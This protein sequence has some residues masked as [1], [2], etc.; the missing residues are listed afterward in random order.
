MSTEPERVPIP[1]SERQPPVGAR[2][3]GSPDPKE[4]MEVSVLLR[5]RTAPAGGGP[6]FTPEELAERP[7][8]DRGYPSRYELAATH[9]ADPTDLNKIKTFAHEHG[10]DVVEESV[11]RRVVILSGTIEALGEAFGVQL[12]TY[13]HGAI[14]YRGY[15]GPLR[16]PAF[17]EEIIQGVFGLDE[18]PIAHP[19]FRARYIRPYAGGISYTPTQVAK[20]YDFPQGASGQ[21]Q[22]IALIELGGGY[23]R[24]D[25]ESYFSGLGV[26]S[27]DVVAVSVDGA[28]NEPTGDPSGPDG[29][30]VL[31]IEVAGALAPGARIVVYFAPNTERGFIDAVSRAVH[32]E[33][34]NPTVISISWGAP[35]DQWSPQSITAFQQSFREAAMLGVTIA[36]AAGDSGSSDG[37]N[38]GLQHVDFPA[39]SPYVLGCGGT[40]LLEASEQGNIA[41]EVVWNEPTDGATGGGISDAFRVPSW[42]RGAHVPPSANPGARVGRGVPDVCGD[43]DPATGYEV[44]V[45]GRRLVVGGTSAVAP[46][47]AAL[48]ARINEVLGQPVGYLNPL[49]YRI[50]TGAGSGSSSTA[51]PFHDITS[52]NN[53]AYAAREGWDACTGLGSPEGSRLLGALQGA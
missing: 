48:T 53:G 44:L 8:V 46:L 27:P 40:R 19:H 43:A 36:C 18:R 47:W 29:E 10:L 21:G 38:D 3:V 5:R 51:Q 49:L 25:L 22:C 23:R 4:R 50:A 31:D 14:T 11:S 15:E 35:E 41:T 32:D 2:V 39:S 20:L 52:G 37:E 16:V 9:G 28:H 33:L 34:N 26:P 30:V 24:Q 12:A 13:E 42:Q 1:A 6:A 45:D 7:P 17:L